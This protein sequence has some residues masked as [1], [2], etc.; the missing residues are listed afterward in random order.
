LGSCSLDFGWFCGGC[1]C[2][3]AG[4]GVGLADV[5]AAFEEGA[6]FDADAGRGY[7]AGEGAFAADV[8][9]VLGVDVAAHFAED[10]DFAGGDVGGYLAI[11]AYGDAIAWQVDGAFDFAVDEERLAAADFTF[12]HQS[13][14]KRGLVAGG[15]SR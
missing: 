1:G 5:D 14:A 8:D 9:A 6:V 7:V 4:F 11:T 10:D 2:R 12:D 3:G 15:G 13:L